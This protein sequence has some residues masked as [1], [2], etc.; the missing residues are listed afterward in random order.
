MVSPAL[1]GNLLK[2]E[3]GTSHNSKFSTAKLATPKERG[4]EGRGEGTPP[5]PIKE[6]DIDIITNDINEIIYNMDGS[7]NEK[8]TI[9]QGQSVCK[10]KQMLKGEMP[11][12]EANKVIYRKALKRLGIGEMK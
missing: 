10:I 11:A 3:V 2:R 4:G 8:E 6:K 5:L 1:H 12:L 9:I 7:L